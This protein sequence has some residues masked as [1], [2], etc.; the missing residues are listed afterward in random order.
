MSPKVPKLILLYAWAPS[1]KGAHL[2]Q[3]LP[4]RLHPGSS[5]RA[6]WQVLRLHEAQPEEGSEP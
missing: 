6:E 5:A 3:R 4:I 2:P 1:P